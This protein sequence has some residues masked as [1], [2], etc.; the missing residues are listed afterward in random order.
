MTGVGMGSPRSL[1]P[2]TEYCQA[3][4]GMLARLGYFLTASPA[5]YGER[6]ANLAVMALRICPPCMFQPGIVMT[7]GMSEPART[8]PILSW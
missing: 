5:R 8:A 2:K 6:S 4:V 1:P 7:S 3:P